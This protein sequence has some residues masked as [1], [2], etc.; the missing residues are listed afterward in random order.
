[1]PRK[2]RQI[3]S[4]LEKYGFINKGGRGSHRNF[5]HPK[6]PYVVVI[7]GKTGDDVKQYQEKA[8]KKAINGV[9]K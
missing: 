4:D 7:S 3:I 6:Y 5:V 2:I 1:M 8:I 9:K